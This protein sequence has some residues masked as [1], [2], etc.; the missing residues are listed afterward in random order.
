MESP[1]QVSQ[2]A[3][4]RRYVNPWKKNVFV[5]S[6]DNNQII[7]LFVNETYLKTQALTPSDQCVLA[8]RSAL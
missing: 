5:I 8:E 3:Q 2:K 4:Q 6:T 1:C 7:V